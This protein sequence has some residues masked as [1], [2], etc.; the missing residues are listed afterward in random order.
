MQIGA[1]FTH[2]HTWC[3]HVQLEATSLS[4]S[5]P[6]PHPFPQYFL[7]LH[8]S[9]SWRHFLPSFL[10]IS[11]SC[12]PVA[13]PTRMALICPTSIRRLGAAQSV[14]RLVRATLVGCC[15]G[16]RPGWGWAKTIWQQMITAEFT[17]LGRY[18]I[19]FRERLLHQPEYP[20]PA[21]IPCST[22]S[23]GYGCWWWR[24]RRH[25]NLP[26][27]Q[28]SATPLTVEL[29]PGLGRGRP[30]PPFPSYAATA[31]T[32]TPCSA[33]VHFGI[34]CSKPQKEKVIFFFAFREHF[35][36]LR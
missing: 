21:A 2:I 16:R 9:F 10:F 14:L 8:I 29:R 25:L 24:P 22:R 27:G 30:L 4:D 20:C 18:S 36:N 11:L 32:T 23:P 35:P 7:S 19:L 3:G 28:P 31:T 17:Q 15:R 6:L 1:H 5:L 12:L 34:I 26:T 13:P 33:P